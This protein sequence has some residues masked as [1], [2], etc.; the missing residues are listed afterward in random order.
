[1]MAIGLFSYY[2]HFPDIGGSVPYMIA[3][4][5]IG[6]TLP[7]GMLLA[8]YFCR[9]RYS[10]LWFRIWLLVWMVAAVM[11]LMLLTP[12]FCGARP[13]GTGRVGGHSDRLVVGSVVYA[14]IL[15]L[16]NL[17]FQELAF[18][19][20]FYRERFEKFFRIEKTPK[21]VPG[22]PFAEQGLWSPAGK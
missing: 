12:R 11:G 10:P 15:Y 13:P 7:M 2:C 3:F 21:V 16:L 17:P 5:V 1:M 19:C 22:C 4:G 6:A 9:R 20:P 14:G 8:S 18:R